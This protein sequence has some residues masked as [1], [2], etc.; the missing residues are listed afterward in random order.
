MVSNRLARRRAAV[1][2]SRE[3]LARV[4]RRLETVSHAVHEESLLASRSRADL[5]ALMEELERAMHRDPN[6]EEQA[7]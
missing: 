3:L 1:R 5:R 7:R 2:E 6:A 4:A